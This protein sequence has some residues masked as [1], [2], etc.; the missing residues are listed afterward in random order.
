MGK[1]IDVVA[2]IVI[3][4]SVASSA[5]C[6]SSGLNTYSSFSSILQRPVG[7]PPG[8]AALRRSSIFA[9]GKTFRNY[10]P[11][12]RKACAM[13]RI[14]LDRDTLAAHS[15]AYGL[16][17][18]KRGPL[19]PPRTS[20]TLLTSSGGDA[21]SRNLYSPPTYSPSGCLPMPVS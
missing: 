12:L 21:S 19:G 10:R 20:L 7:P 5:R 6:V 4:R 1:V 16:I 17:S 18:A 11:H 15:A 13:A 14:P 2:Q 3:L 8:D 9:T